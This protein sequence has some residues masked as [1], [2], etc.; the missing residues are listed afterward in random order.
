MKLDFPGNLFI[1]AFN[2]IF[3]LILDIIFSETVCL[4]NIFLRCC[5]LHTLVFKN[6]EGRYN[7]II[8]QLRYLKT[9]QL[10]HL[11]VSGAESD[12]RISL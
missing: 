6:C 4:K 10:C 1:L 7:K 5:R 2:G 3:V 12:K 9:Y 8:K 11:Q